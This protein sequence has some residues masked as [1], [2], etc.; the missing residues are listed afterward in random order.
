MKQ[1]SE[2]LQVWICATL[3]RC[4]IP[5][6]ARCHVNTGSDATAAT[7]A[8]ARSRPASTEVKNALGFTPTHNVRVHVVVLTKN[9]NYTFTLG[10]P[11]LDNV[12]NASH[13]SSRSAYL[14]DRIL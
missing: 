12:R 2:I 3:D 1:T 6:T 14:T 5:S 7:G 9:H 4:S 8:A 11:F 10:R 13:L